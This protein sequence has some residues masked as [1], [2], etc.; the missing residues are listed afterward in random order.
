MTWGNKSLYMLIKIKI[1]C[2]IQL[3]II[4]GMSVK[5]LFH[6]MNLYIIVHAL[7]LPLLVFT[8]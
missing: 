1:M 8:D 2:V 5:H 3:F 7:T 4:L 6:A